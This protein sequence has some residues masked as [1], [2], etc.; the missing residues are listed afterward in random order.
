MGLW[1]C[2]L[3]TAVV[4]AV[5]A[6]VPVGAQSQV[7]TGR[8]TVRAMLFDGQG[9]DDFSH[10]GSG[11]LR[12]PNVDSLARDGAFL[13]KFYVCPV[14]VPTRAKFLTRRYHSRDGAPAFPKVTNDCRWRPKPLQMFFRRPVIA[15]WRS[16]SG[17]SACSCLGIG[18]AVA[19]VKSMVSVAVT[20]G[21]TFRYRWTTTQ[22]CV[23]KES[24]LCRSSV[25]VELSLSAGAAS[26]AAVINE[27]NESVLIG[28]AEGRGSAKGIADEGLPAR[29]PWSDDA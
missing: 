16:V 12:T 2:L 17:M 1:R 15:R 27:A 29:E 24:C 6:P 7:E 14:C 10:R 8:S 13:S 23:G 26:V 21:I 18:S 3:L 11:D 19:F 20:V 28:D 5:A 4:C 22:E 9:F 25:G